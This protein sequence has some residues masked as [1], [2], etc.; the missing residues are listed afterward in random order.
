MVEGLEYH[1]I[2]PL[3]E[4]LKAKEMKKGFRASL[5]IVVAMELIQHL[6]EADPYNEICFKAL[7]LQYYHC[8]YPSAD[9]KRLEVEFNPPIN[10]LLAQTFFE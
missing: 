2:R 4:K 3:A 1:E 9:G 7:I 5:S 10:I 8:A 6:E